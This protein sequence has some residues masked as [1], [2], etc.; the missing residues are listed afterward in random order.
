MPSCLIWHSVLER[1]V[2]RVICDCDRRHTAIELSVQLK[3]AF[4]LISAREWNVSKTPTRKIT[5]M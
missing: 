2:F 1:A 3:Y 5:P 4:A